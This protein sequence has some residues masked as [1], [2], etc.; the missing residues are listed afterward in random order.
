MAEIL[1]KVRVIPAVVR[2]IAAGDLEGLPPD[3]P[4]Q[5][6][7]FVR[8]PVSWALLHWGEM[9]GGREQKK[10]IPRFWIYPVTYERDEGG[11]HQYHIRL[12]GGKMVWRD[13]KLF[14]K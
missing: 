11:C 6:E 4:E 3:A 5:I 13:S 14:S 1:F 8:K 2:R 9:D 12:I 10:M 7:E